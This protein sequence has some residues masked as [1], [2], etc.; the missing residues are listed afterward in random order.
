M[1]G[2]LLISCATVFSWFVRMQVRGGFRDIDGLSRRTMA[3]VI[4]NSVM[5][6]LTEAAKSSNYDSPVQ[7]WYKPFMLNVPDMGIWVIQIT[8][9]DDKIPLLVR[10]NLFLSD[11]TLTP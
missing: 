5:L 4:S 10:G 3:H 11:G 9:L 7:K 6:L 2:V 8:P 1:L